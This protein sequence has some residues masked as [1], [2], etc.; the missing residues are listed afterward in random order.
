MPEISGKIEFESYDLADVIGNFIDNKLS[1][2]DDDF[3]QRLIMGIEQFSDL[4][5]NCAEHISYDSLIEGVTENI[6][7]NHIEEV[8]SA[9]SDDI[10]TALDD[11]IEFCDF[12]EKYI[13]K[14][15]QTRYMSIDE[16]LTKQA[17]AISTLTQIVDSMQSK[18]F[19]KKL[20]K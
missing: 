5:E 19:W 4:A 9:I 12:I 13:D 6:R 16:V 18:K 11:N 1:S 3:M 10:V 14:A 7:F 8:S 15:I 17:I 2:R 20:I